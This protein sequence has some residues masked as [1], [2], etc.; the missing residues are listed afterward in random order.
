VSATPVSFQPSQTTF[1]E[2]GMGEVIPELSIFGI[3][4]NHLICGVDN[5]DPSPE[6]HGAKQTETGIDSCAP[7]EA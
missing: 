1:L 4:V 5:F 2:M 3:N 7:L 6:K